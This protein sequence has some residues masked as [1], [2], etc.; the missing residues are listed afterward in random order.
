M[1]LRWDAAERHVINIARSEY[2]LEWRQIAQL[3]ADIFRVD[4][5]GTAL[6]KAGRLRNEYSSRQ[7]KMWAEEIIKAQYTPAEEAEREQ[8]RESIKVAAQNL[9][10][11]LEPESTNG[12][13]A[14]EDGD[15]GD[16]EAEDGPA[17]VD[18]LRSR[19]ARAARDSLRSGNIAKLVQRRA[20]MRDPELKPRIPPLPEPDDSELLLRSRNGPNAYHDEQGKSLAAKLA[21]QGALEWTQRE[22][23]AATKL[24]H[25]HRPFA[26]YL[27]KSGQ[28]HAVATGQSSTSEAA[29][30]G[31]DGGIQM[32]GSRDR[33]L[34]QNDR[35]TKDSN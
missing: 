30:V 4:W 31:P 23:H 26:L 21:D 29:E 28:A 34:H 15:G 22:S 7:A 1:P 20:S 12:P 18:A 16:E 6:P 17:T 3:F 33:Q 19:I 14:S 8:A 9:D 35:A 27:Q 32:N 10:I 24:P 11:T 2:Q 5:Q 25:G 13:A